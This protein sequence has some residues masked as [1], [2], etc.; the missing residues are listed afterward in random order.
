M[1]EYTLYDEFFDNHYDNISSSRFKKQ[2]ISKSHPPKNKN[3]QVV[4]IGKHGYTRSNLLVYVVSDITENRVW[5]M[6]DKG[7][8]LIVSEPEKKK[9]I[10]DGKTVEISEET[11]NWLK[12]QIEEL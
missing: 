3:L 7:L 10:M 11:Y 12:K 5:L 6:A 4:Y 8:E 2:F 9:I 1:V